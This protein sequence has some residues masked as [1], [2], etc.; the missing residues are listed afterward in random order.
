MDRNKFS[1]V[2]AFTETSCN[3]FCRKIF[4]QTSLAK[5]MIAGR[6]RG[7]RK[8][9]WSTPLMCFPKETIVISKI[10]KEK[11]LAVLAFFCA[12]PGGM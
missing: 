10:N 7:K 6:I 11:L 3:F 1:F 12:Q 5:K 9:L 4:S 8:E 2:G